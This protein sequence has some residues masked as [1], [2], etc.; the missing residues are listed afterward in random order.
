M[1]NW[2][3]KSEP[4]DFSIDDLREA[5]TTRWDSIRNYGAR[6]RLKECVPG[7]RVLFYHSGRKASVVGVARVASKPYPDPLQFEPESDYCDPKSSPDDPKW[8]AVDIA[9]VRALDEPVTLKSMKAEEAL[10]GLEVLAQPRLSVSRVGSAEFE[11]V[12][13]P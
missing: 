11:R 4:D 8:W 6:N 7:D 2:L 5:G 10:S 1:A 3:F 13:N 12:L 9:F